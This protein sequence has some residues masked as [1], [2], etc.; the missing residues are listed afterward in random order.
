MSQCLRKITFP[1]A[2][3]TADYDVFFSQHKVQCTKTREHVFVK[4]SFTGIV[5]IAKT[6]ILP[7][8]CLF[9]QSINLVVFAIFPLV[10][11]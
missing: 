1:C 5:Y 11:G 3:G 6:G 9:Q 7:K 10:I 2:G 4:I 8:V